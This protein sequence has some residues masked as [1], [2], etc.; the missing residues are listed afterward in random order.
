MIE[1]QI[2]ATFGRKPIMLGK[3][4]HLHHHPVDEEP[5]NPESSDD[6]DA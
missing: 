1:A 3:G 5:P 2:M 6:E 4:N